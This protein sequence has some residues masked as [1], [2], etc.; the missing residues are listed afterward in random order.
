MDASAPAFARKL[1]V[2]ICLSFALYGASLSAQI[3]VVLE[4]FGT[5]GN[6][7]SVI[8]TSTWNTR[9]SQDST[10]LTVSGAGALDDQGWSA[11]GLNI[12]GTGAT[13]FQVTAQ[14]ASTNVAPFI[15]LQMTD[16]SLNTAVASLS[17]SLFN[18][19]SMTTANSSG[20]SF[21]L[22]SFNFSQISSWTFGGGS[23]GINTLNI[24]FDNLALAVPEPSTYAL[25]ALGMGLI[26]VPILRRRRS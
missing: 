15:V 20:F 12:N 3:I 8:P 24:S 19:T 9:V 26:A 7:G 25:L 16:S 14:L 1:L 23:T 5:P 4:T 21:P 11:T 6:T 17:T 18:T 10:A 13:V 2:S 22:G